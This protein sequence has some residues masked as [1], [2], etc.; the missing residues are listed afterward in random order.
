MTVSTLNRLL[1]C[2]F[3]TWKGK[4]FGPWGESILLFYNNK[5]NKATSADR[6][7]KQLLAHVVLRSDMFLGELNCLAAFGKSDLFQNIDFWLYFTV[8]THQ[9]HFSV[10]AFIWGD[11][12][13]INEENCSINLRFSAFSQGRAE[14]FRFSLY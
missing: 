1:L 8:N 2:S 10:I 14:S 11:C 7:I 4:V 5:I 3:V 6:L 12:C 9:G 13:T